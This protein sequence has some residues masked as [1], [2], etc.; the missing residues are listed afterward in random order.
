[1]IPPWTEDQDALLREKWATG[2]NLKR[3]LPQFGNRAYSSV[4]THAHRDLKLGPR[5]KSARG[6]P[7]YAWDLIVAELKKAPGT[8][9]DLQRRAGLKSSISRR[10]LVE[11]NPG[12]HGKV[13]IVDWQKRSNGGPAVAVFALGPG[14]NA[15]KPAP[16]TNTEKW[17]KKVSRKQVAADPFAV[18]AG[19]VAAPVIASIP[20][21]RVY[22][23]SMS[24][25]DDEEMAA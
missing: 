14:K 9:P 5:L 16:F 22:Q 11:A 17:Q 6:V 23:Q 15:P 21:G 2:E 8:Y 3:Y 10:L 7:A 20:K 18:A 13:H 24:I 4:I 12:P 19:L 1:M 25:K